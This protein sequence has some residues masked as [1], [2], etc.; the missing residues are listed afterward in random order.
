MILVVAPQV[1]VWW[2]FYWAPET[3]GEHLNLPVVVQWYCWWKKF[4]IH[5]LRLVVYPIIYCT[6]FD[7]SQVVSRIS[8][9]NS[10]KVEV[11]L[12]D[13]D[14]GES[15]S[16]KPTASWHLK[17]DAWKMKFSL[18]GALLVL[19]SASTGLVIRNTP[20]ISHMWQFTRHLSFFPKTCWWELYSS[21]DM[22]QGRQKWYWC[23]KCSSHH[24]DV[25]GIIVWIL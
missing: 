24:F 23:F 4:C 19:R 2:Q 10:I 22:G 11:F 12:F 17:I 21:I 13:W 8:S 25:H 5:Q 7:T 20:V 18:S 3:W 9:I 6:G 15:P 16:L 1:G 14:G